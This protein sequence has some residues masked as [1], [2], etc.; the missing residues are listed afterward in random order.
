M[1]PWVLDVLYVGAAVITVGGAVVWPA[2]ALLRRRT[3]RRLRAASQ[4]TDLRRTIAKFTGAALSAH[5]RVVTLGRLRASWVPMSEQ[6]AVRLGEPLLGQTA[7]IAALRSRIRYSGDEETNR[8]ADKV[9]HVL[10]E[11]ANLLT[12]RKLAL[13]RVDWAD[14]EAAIAEA[15]RGLEDSVR[16]N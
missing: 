14:R 3:L 13:R 15:L 12:G 2:R 5:G 9:L 16:Q 1:E 6:T 7:P 4:E 10:E 8:A 11:S